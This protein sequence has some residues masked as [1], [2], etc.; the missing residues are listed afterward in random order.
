MEVIDAFNAENKHAV[1]EKEQMWIDKLNPSLNMINA[2]KQDSVKE[3]N[4]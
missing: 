4:F 2:L 1:Q 3:F